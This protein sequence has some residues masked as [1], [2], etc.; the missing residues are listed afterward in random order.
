[1][2]KTLFTML[3][4]N[5]RWLSLLNVKSAS[6]WVVINREYC[7]HLL[8]AGV[9]CLVWYFFDGRLANG[10]ANL[11]L[12]WHYFRDVIVDFWQLWQVKQYE[13]HFKNPWPWWRHRRRKPSSMDKR[14]FRRDH[15]DIYLRNRKVCHGMWRMLYTE[16][17]CYDV[18]ILCTWCWVR[19]FFVVKYKVVQGIVCNW[20]F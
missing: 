17:P 9:V 8:E 19:I 6:L 16:L 4:V 15:E 7:Q 11:D 10:I 12:L 3:S 2:S 14:I 20:L 18:R 13:W 5:S 1:M